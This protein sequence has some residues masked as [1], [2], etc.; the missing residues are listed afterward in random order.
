MNSKFREFFEISDHLKRTSLA[1]LVLFAACSV[2]L[3]FLSGLFG[4]GTGAS[5]QEKKSPDS[6]L[7]PLW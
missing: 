7:Y 3:N 5:K 2:I 6:D 1:S 4:D